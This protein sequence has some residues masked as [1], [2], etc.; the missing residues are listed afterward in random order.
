MGALS[1]VSETTL[2]PTAS[3]ELEEATVL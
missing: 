2:A 3:E 1:A